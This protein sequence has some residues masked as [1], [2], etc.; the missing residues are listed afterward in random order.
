RP[1]LRQQLREKAEQ[2]LQ[3]KAAQRQ[4][5]VAVLT[6]QERR[7]KDEVKELEKESD[8]V[9]MGT[10]EI[11]S[12]RDEIAREDEAAQALGAQ[13]QARPRDCQ[14][15]RR[16]GVRGGA[17]A[18]PKAARRLVAAA[19]A[20]AAVFLLV[21]AGIAWREFQA[22]RVC[23]IQDVVEGLGITLVGAV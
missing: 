1:L 3:L 21:L 12:L 17:P 8:K 13:M 4:E 10:A 18:S 5:R 16:V 14:A 20:G 7:L 19:G 15:A 22:R 23:R 11:A 6:E 9:K 2:D